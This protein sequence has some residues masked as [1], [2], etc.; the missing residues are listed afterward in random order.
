[1]FRNGNLFVATDGI[2]MILIFVGKLFI[3]CASTFACYCIIMYSDL[4]D[5]V[6]SPIAPCVVIFI[7]TYFIAYMLLNIYGVAADSL[8]Q[9]YCL[10]KEAAQ[11]EG[12]NTHTPD[13][14]KEFV[15]KHE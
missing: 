9:C 6:Y 7:L 10:D 4:A 1:M 14:L 12:R 2:G 8:L 5:E 3:A 11:A 13:T 15:D